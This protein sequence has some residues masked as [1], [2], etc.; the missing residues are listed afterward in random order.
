MAAGKS[1]GRILIV[2]QNLAGGGAERVTL[3][4]A[5]LLADDGYDVHLLLH[6]NTGDLS[7]RPGG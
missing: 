7:S 6:E 5:G 2:M 4:L 1:R 3:D